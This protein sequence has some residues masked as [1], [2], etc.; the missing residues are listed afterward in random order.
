MSASR[1]RLHP[2]WTRGAV[3]LVLALVASVLLWRSG[4][5][6]GAVPQ[7]R[8]PE[9]AGFYEPR[10]EQ[11]SAGEHG[12]LIWSRRIVTGPTIGGT[13]HLLLYRST[14]AKGETVAVSG[15]V[16]TPAG[17]PPEGGWPV[18]AWGHG[19][20]GTADRCAPSRSAADQQTG[21]YTAAMDRMTAGLVEDGYAVVRTDYEGLGTPGPHPYLMGQSA[22]AAMADIVLAAHELTPE[23]SDE[24]VAMGHSQGGQ[25]A[26][27][28]SRFTGAYTS[29]LDLRG[30]V[31]LAPPSQLGAVVEMVGGGRSASR[32]E[33]EAQ[34]RAASTSSTATFLGPLLV[35]AARTG[36][37]PLEQVV[38]PQGRDLLPHLEERCV[39]ELFRPD[40]FGGVDVEDFLAV[41]ADLE[42]LGRVVGTNDAAE[43]HPQVPVVLVQGTR[44]TTVPRL[45]S[46]RLAEQYRERGAD[47]EYVTVPGADHVSVLDEAA[48]TVRTWVTGAFDG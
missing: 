31:A 6:E 14:S 11:V 46:D 3:V 41:E 25:A 20:T 30:I 21:V 19:T 27:F 33:E 8:A 48:P 34:E 47:L 42:R 15:V 37:V 5:P 1:P 39:A 2:W 16:S 17:D 35:A 7:E 18:I 28:T 4:P 22:G 36:D 13:T 29:G 26:L 32:A 24:W 10:P 38:S 12:S 9:G 44:D 45:L 23:L 43:L 40:S